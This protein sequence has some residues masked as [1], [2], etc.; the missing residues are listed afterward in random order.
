[1]WGA[2]LDAA[3]GA[4]F[5]E[6]RRGQREPVASL[7]GT[8]GLLHGESDGGLGA[9]NASLGAAVEPAFGRVRLQLGIHGEYFSIARFTRY[10]RRVG[11]GVGLG[12]GFG[13]DLAQGDWGG[14]YLAVRGDIAEVSDATVGGGTLKLGGRFVY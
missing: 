2:E 12:G 1:M 10:V 4:E 5:G 6:I 3:I 13:V 8:L 14:I 11:F 7:Y 9:T